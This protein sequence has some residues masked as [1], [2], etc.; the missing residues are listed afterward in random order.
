VQVEVWFDYLCPWCYLA[1][2]RV[3]YLRDRHGLD[4]R[5]RPFELHPEIPPGG[6]DLAGRPGSGSAIRRLADEAGLPIAPRR[7]SNNTRTALAFSTWAAPDP[8]WEGLHRGLFHAYWAEGADLEDPDVLVGVATE[9]GIDPAHSRQAIE[10]GAGM[11]A[12]HDSRTAAMDLGIGATPGWHFGDG[13]VFT[14]VHPDAVMDRIVGR[15][16]ERSTRP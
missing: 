3:R 14:G 9:V 12:V 6:A 7:R 10:A 15:A 4:V 2:D 8:G 16:L 1:T 11:T 13:V 5:W